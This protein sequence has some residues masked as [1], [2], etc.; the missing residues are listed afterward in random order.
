MLTNYFNE[1]KLTMV[2]QKAESLG[3]PEDKKE[4]LL[5]ISGGVLENYMNNAIDELIKRYGSVQ[6]YLSEELGV[7]KEEIDILRRR[8]LN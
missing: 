7:G 2:R 8:Y 3:M 6:G 5:F 4:L 1:M